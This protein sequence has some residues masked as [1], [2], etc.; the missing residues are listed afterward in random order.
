[1]TAYNFSA[2]IPNTANGPYFEPG[3]YYEVNFQYSLGTGLAS[4]DTI[5]TPSLGL[6]S[7]GIRIVDIIVTH[8]ELDTNA[9][10]TGTYDIGDSDDQNRF[11]SASLLGVNGVTT[12]GFTMTN[13]INIAQ[14]TTNG[15]V[16]TGRGYLYAAGTD[17]R[18]ILTV[19]SAVATA[20]TSGVINMKVCYTCSGEY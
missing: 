14:G 4:G 13:P 3:Q 8:P 7:N 16:T 10:P 6:P 5:T 12:A 20:A 17:P 15:V 11:Q 1:M 2:L 19:I 9:T 18:L